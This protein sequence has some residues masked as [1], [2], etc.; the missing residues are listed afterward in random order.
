[1]AAVRWFSG[2]AKAQ[3]GRLLTPLVTGIRVRGPFRPDW[4]PA[5][6]RHVFI[7]TE[8]LLH[9]KSS[10]DV[11]NELTSLFKTVDTILL[12][13]SA[14]NALHSPAAAKVF[15][16]VSSTGYTA[17]FALSFTHMDQASGENLQTAKAKREH[18]FGGVRNILDNQVAKNVSRDAARQLESH[19]N[20]NTFYFAYLDPKKYPTNDEAQASKFEKSIAR[21]LGE[22]AASIASRT[23][24]DLRLPAYPKYSMHSL[25]I[26]V[27][28]GSLAFVEAW[29][30]RLGF[31]RVEG[32][33]TAP[34]Q[35]IK[36]MSRRYAEGWLWDGFWLRPIDNLTTTMRNVLSKF[37]DNPMEWGGKPATDE[38]KAAV[39]DRIKQD[40]SGKLADL[41]K[42]RLREKPLPDWQEAYGFRDRGSTEKRRHRVR[43]IFQVQIPI[44]ESVSDR[45]AQA[46]IEIFEKL[47]TEA[48]DRL[49]QQVEGR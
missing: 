33:S 17:R 46:W 21:Q 34:W 13:E 5:D 11:P 4:A 45:L 8:G 16:A 10:A 31:K 42:D 44:P 29:E 7:D 23:Q 6:Y 30:A 38:Q 48:V 22:L 25:G 19:L 26:A 12:V 32:L 28:E 43:G 27:R 47:I 3:W 39:I 41:A 20:G 37:L 2:N 24:P 35:S 15:E 36:A 40:L 18:V 9:S 1:M 14:K 49:K